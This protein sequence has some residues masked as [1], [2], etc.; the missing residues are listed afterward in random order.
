MYRLQVPYT[1][2]Q[3]VQPLSVHRLISPM[4]QAFQS[5]DTAYKGNRSLALLVGL[6]CFLTFYAPLYFQSMYGLWRSEEH[7]H[8]PLIFMIAAWLI[9]QFRDQLHDL[10]RSGTPSSTGWLFVLFGIGLLLSGRALRFSIVEFSSQPVIALGILLLVGGWKMARLCWFPL[11]F[12]CFMVPLPGIFVDAATSTLKQWVSEL[13]ENLL[14]YAGYPIGRAGVMLVVGQYQLLVA[15]ACSGLN[16]MFTLSAMGMLFMYLRRRSNWLH[17]TLML[18]A[19][20]PIAFVT[21][22]IRVMI[23]VLITYHLG[24]EAGQGFMHSAAGIFMMVTALLCFI[25]WDVVLNFIFSQF[26]R[27]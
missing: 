24:D 21:N 1:S 3:M 5:S 15:D 16:S 8:A 25:I 26:R 18:L 27:R 20:L 10:A 9:W 13:A 4:V 22:I 19:I 12:L 6:A 11:L 14:A 7:A 2:K 17:N 23:L